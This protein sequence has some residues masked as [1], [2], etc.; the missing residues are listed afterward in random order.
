MISLKKYLDFEAPDAVVNCVPDEGDSL[1]AAI[2]AYRSALLE[3]G[4]CSLDACPA[5][6]AEL[7]RSLGGLV[8]S[9]SAG[10]SSADLE[11]TDAHVQEQLRD[12]GKR[13]ASHY[14]Q[15][16]AEV[17]GLLIVMARTA[18]SVGERDQRCAGQ[19]N[20]V[21]ARL[22]A[23]ASLDDLTEIRA[24]VERSAAELKTSVERMAAEGKAAL[25][26]LRSEV[27]SYQ[28][29][30]EEAEEL[31]SRDGL[32]GLRGRIWVESQIERRIGEG[33]PLCVA[34]IDIDEFKK[35]ND[36]YG[37]LTGDELL[38][39]FAEEL[40]SACRSTDKIGR[41]GGDE[42]IV[43]LECGMR[44]AKGQIDR[45]RAWVCGD[46][47]VKGITALRKLSVEASIGLA[48][49]LPNEPMKELLDRADADMYQQKAGHKNGRSLKR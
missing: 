37:H 33:A 41:W 5:L 49:H 39:Q 29:K 1:S 35:V 14:G 40:L 21:T 36:E 6:G 20:E 46:Y 25:E 22:E 26:Q 30:L 3:M 32:T 16:T 18:E 38:K 19:I 13:T 12:W 31:A 11:S 44:E 24:S 42:F 17:K 43:L 47:K 2:G 9:L 7:K 10:M 28:A 34:I 8:E 23:I 15:K 45:L 27:S 4:N 48:E